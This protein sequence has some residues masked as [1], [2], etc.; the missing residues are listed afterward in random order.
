MVDDIP[1]R[2]YLS[3]TLG[4]RNGKTPEPEA[5]SGRSL[6]SKETGIFSLNC[7]VLARAHAQALTLGCLVGFDV[8]DSWLYKILVGADVRSS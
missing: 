5:S 7:G 6:K 8:G 1:R 3:Q 4:H 2:M